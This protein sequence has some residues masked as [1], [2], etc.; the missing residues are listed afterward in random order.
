[1]DY[2]TEKKVRPLY[3]A[4]DEG[5]NKLALQH[6][7]KLLKKNPDWPLIKALKALVLVRIGKEEEAFDLCQQVKAVIPTDE[8][9]LQ[10]SSMALKELGKHS[11]IVELYENA[12]NLQPKNEEF[13][14]HWFMAM[15]RNSDYKGQQAAAVKL[16]RLFKHNKYLFWAIMSLAL[17]G[18]DRNKIAYT[19]A[20]RMMGKAM[21]EGRL[22]QVEHMRLFLLILMDQGKYKE[23]LELLDTTYKEESDK[24]SK[25]LNLAEK[26][27]K[28]P[29]IRQIKSELLRENQCWDAVMEMSREVLEKENS[30]DWFHWLAYFEAMDAVVKDNENVIAKTEQLIEATQKV[31]LNN[32]KFLKRGPFLAELELDYRLFKLGKRDENTVLEHLISY[33]DRFGSKSCVFEDLQTYV[34]FLKSDTEKATFLLNQFKSTIHP[35]SEKAARIKNVYKNVN[36]RKLEH[37]LGLH[38]I[39]NQEQALSLVT[40]L[41]NEYQEALPLGEHLEKTEMQFGDEFVILASH[42]LLELYHQQNKYNAY[43]IQAITLL[44]TALTKSIHNFQMKLILVRMYLMLGVY[45]RAF[46]I[47]R[48]M[49]IKQIQF[50]TMIHY[51]TDKFISLGCNDQLESIFYESL[52]IYKSNEVETPEMLVKAYQ[53]GTFSK[54]QEFIEF[55]RRLDTSLQHTITN[56]ETTRMGFTHSSF[57]TKYAIQYFQELDVA[58]I[59]FTETFIA[60]RSDNRDFK[61]FSNFN[62]EDQTTAETLCK[63]V[64]SSSNPVWAQIFGY[65]LN[66]MSVVCE[67]KDTSRALSGL[68]QGLKQS[69]AKENIKAFITEKE[70]SLA[71]YVAELAEALDCIK[72]RGNNDDAAKTLQEANDILKHQ[73]MDAGSFTEENSCWSTFHSVS[74]TLEAFNYGSVLIEML[75]RALGLNSKDARRKASEKASSD[76]FMASFIELQETAKNSLLN[77]QKISREGKNLFKFQLQ[78]RLCKAILAPDNSATASFL[79][80]SKECQDMLTNKIL[81]DM[82]QS[83]NLSVTQLSDE[84]DRRVQKL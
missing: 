7:A 81:K 12:A 36:I 5:Q 49:E 73:L 45:T 72:N 60:E 31:M 18:N 84:I 43:L 38:S 35:T 77:I 53:F 27:L 44:E 83:W 22:D 39:V 46:E 30:D 57:Q 26:A 4:I 33:F 55:R 13:A 75:N 8:P 69:L 37:V 3:E 10:A 16:H 19:L 68:V 50:D 67:T 80:T 52:S 21:Q 65:V 64:M 9:T 71:S 24:S 74:I 79:K 11:V 61:V 70:L 32:Q 41:W 6:C 42:V 1:M 51:F 17:Q 34:D 29:E 15:V 59:G 47:Y 76:L 56:I 82:V 78:K 66:I 48:T 40:E 28:D 63:P 25:G 58:S 54:I 2:A 23:A 62:N 20:E 14:N